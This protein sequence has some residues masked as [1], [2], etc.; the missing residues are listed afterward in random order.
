MSD[1]ADRRRA[2]QSRHRFPLWR[3]LR[4]SLDTY[5]R[6]RPS[7]WSWSQ[8]PAWWCQWAPEPDSSNPAIN[9]S[10]SSLVSTTSRSRRPT[11]WV[12]TTHQRRGQGVPPCRRLGADRR[13]WCPAGTRLEKEGPFEKVLAGA[14]RSIAQTYSQRSEDCASDAELSFYRIL[15]ISDSTRPSDSRAA[16]NCWLTSQPLRLTSFQVSLPRSE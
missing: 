13:C 14:D 3:K 11:S 16:S 8:S 7:A 1:R 2:P 5:S 12:R 9:P 6:P 10:T 15:L 4:L